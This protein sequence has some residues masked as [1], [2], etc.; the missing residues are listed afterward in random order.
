VPVTPQIEDPVA[1]RVGSANTVITRFWDFSP[2]WIERYSRRASFKARLG[3]VSDAIDAVLRCRPRAFVLDFG[4]GPGVF[5]AL[6]SSLAGHVICLD[7]SMGMIRAGTAKDQLLSDLVTSTGRTYRRDKIS[8]VVGDIDSIGT[9]AVGAFDLVLAVAVLEYLPDVDRHIRKLLSLTAPGGTFLFTV[10]NPSSIVRRIERPFD[11]F[12]SAAGRILGSRR[13]TDRTYSSLRVNGSAVL[14]QDALSTCVSASIT[15]IG[16][17]LAAT[18]MRSHVHPSTM[19][20]AR[21]PD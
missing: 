20:L 11:T 6:A 10:P 2:T 7:P 18:G 5:S 1:E 12:A 15:T 9:S 4:G 13:L 17:P 3:I 16:L 21:L 14:W 19:V 8:R